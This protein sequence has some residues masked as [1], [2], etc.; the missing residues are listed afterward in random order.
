MMW[1][2]SN[3]NARFLKTFDDLVLAPRGFDYRVQFTGPTGANGVEAALRLARKVTGRTNVVAITNGFHGVTQGA[4]V[5]T[6]NQHHRICPTI[7]LA[8]EFR[9]TFD[10]YLGNE[11]NTAD[12]LGKLL[13]DPS[14]GLDAPA[15]ILLK[16]V[17]GG[18]RP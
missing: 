10:G 8:N 2:D 4:L 9:A 13:H 15:A 14:S 11:F 17:Q 12:L 6:A 5:A 7:P 3:Q 18:V 16:P 1:G